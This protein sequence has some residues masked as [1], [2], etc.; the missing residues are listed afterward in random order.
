MLMEIETLT[1]VGSLIAQ[2][3]GSGVVLVFLWIMWREIKANGAET[4]K[5]G[6]RLSTLEGYIQG[7]KNGTG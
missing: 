6:Q 5:N 4:R 1:Q 3:G 2:N 7:K